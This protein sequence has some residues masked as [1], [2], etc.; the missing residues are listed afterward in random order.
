M[1]TLTYTQNFA[2]HFRQIVDLENSNQIFKKNSGSTLPHK[3]NLA[4]FIVVM[5]YLETIMGQLGIHFT[6]V[7]SQDSLRME[8]VGLENKLYQVY[9]NLSGSRS[10]GSHYLF[11]IDLVLLVRTSYSGTK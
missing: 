9:I 10:H 3:E 8:F 11:Y 6:T 4:V 2:Y 7:Y 5:V 1:N